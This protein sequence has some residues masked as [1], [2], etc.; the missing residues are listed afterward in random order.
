MISKSEIAIIVVNHNVDPK[1]QE[2][3]IWSVKGSAGKI[4]VDI[5]LGRHTDKN[6]VFRKTTILN[7]I[8]RKNI[9]SYKYI[10]QTDIDMLIPPH[11]INNTVSKVQ[12]HV[13]CF[14][15]NYRYVEAEEVNAWM[16]LGYA[17]TP[18][19]DISKRPLFRA[20]GSW[21]GMNRDCWKKSNGFCEEIFNLG[22]P[23]TEFYIRTVK[24]QI[25]WYKD[26]STPLAHINH[27][28]RSV[29]K[30]GEKNMTL[31]GKFKNDFN[32]LQNRYRGVC[33]TIIEKI[34]VR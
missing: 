14:H 6:S 8:L 25:P 11:I 32:W 12:D 29:P 33:E 16:K 30:Q 26:D 2:R 20:S 13:R 22:G 5:I 31:A 24:N 15:V 23:D 21:N 17:S 4:P 3:F 1:I 10:V 7:D 34:N 9:D 19:K 18:W 28:R 27:P